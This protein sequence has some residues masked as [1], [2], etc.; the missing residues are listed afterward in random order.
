[1]TIILKTTMCGPHGSFQAGQRADL[2]AKTERDLVMGGYATDVSP[3]Q[4]ITLPERAVVA[5]A[6][7]HAVAPQQPVV[8]QRTTRRG[9]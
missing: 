8:P 9:R 5:P 7:E 3:R 2:D 1:M 6:V 4:T